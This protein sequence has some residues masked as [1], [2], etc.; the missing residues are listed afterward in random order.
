MKIFDRRQGKIIKCL[1]NIHSGPINCVRWDPLGNRLV[2]ASYDRSVKV[3]DFANEKVIYTGE[4][5]DSIL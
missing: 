1:N 4:T 3:I 5:D 2:T